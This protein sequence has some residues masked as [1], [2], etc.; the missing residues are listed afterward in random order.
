VHFRRV[1]AVEM[2]PA[3][4]GAWP[5]GRLI[6]RLSRHH[7][8]SAGRKRFAIWLR[9][10][11][12]SPLCR[13]SPNCAVPKIAAEPHRCVGAAPRDQSAT[14]F[15]LIARAFSSRSRRLRGV[16]RGRHALI[17]DGSQRSQRR[18]RRRSRTRSKC[19]N[20][21]SRSSPIGV[22]FELVKPNALKRTQVPQSRGDIQRQLTG[23]LPRRNPGGEIDLAFRRSISRG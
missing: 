21:R 18:R 1:E 12:R 5:F 2:R 8:A 20:V 19:T 9:V 7:A 17:L 6:A 22:S 13:S 4:R 3:P 16:C 23:L 11:A 14:R 10:R 15:A